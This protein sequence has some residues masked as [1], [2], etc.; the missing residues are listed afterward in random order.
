L[1]AAKSDVDISGSLGSWLTVIVKSVKLSQS[2]F[3]IET[4]T[5]SIHCVDCN[6]DLGGSAY[7]DS[8]GNC[9]GGN[10]G[11]EENSADLG[12]GCDLPEPLEYWEDIDGVRS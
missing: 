7:I 3:E 2:V 5:Q 6:G 4:V 1:S 11:L 12:C 10:T 9:V 8:C